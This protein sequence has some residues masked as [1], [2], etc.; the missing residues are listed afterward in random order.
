[1]LVLGVRAGCRRRVRALDAG[2]GCG[3]WVLALYAGCVGAG[4]GR[5]VRAVWALGVGVEAGHERLDKGTER[6]LWALGRTF[7][8]S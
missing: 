3:R 6:G 7:N 8:S 1:M 2:A 4:Y 5:Y